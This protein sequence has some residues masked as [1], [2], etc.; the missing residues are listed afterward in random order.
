MFSQ[1]I[2]LSGEAF[3]ISMTS[4]MQAKVYVY[5]KIFKASY[6]YLKTFEKSKLPLINRE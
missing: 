6:K 5:W 3:I 4:S 1:N 2:F